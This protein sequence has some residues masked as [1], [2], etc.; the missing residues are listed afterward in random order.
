MISE[1]YKT[2]NR[3]LHEKKPTYGAGGHQYLSDISYYLRPGVSVLDYGCGKGTFKQAVGS[4][5]RVYEYDPALDKD[6]RREVD[7]V[8]CVDVMEHIEPEYLDEVLA[9]IA[10]YAKNL[11]FLAI[12]CRPAKKSLP[13]GRNAHLIVKEPSWWLDK[14]REHM[15][16]Q[17]FEQD[18]DIL[19]VWGKP[20]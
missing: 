7:I 5:A 2:M 12:C 15:R 9:D 3:L 18:G 20:K 14:V 19:K 13:D 4:Q 16:V 10:S 8:Y 11:I 17:M 6:E 1:E